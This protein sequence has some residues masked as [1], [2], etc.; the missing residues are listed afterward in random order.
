VLAVSAGDDR[1]DAARPEFA[2]VLVVV[3]A[4]VG[5]ETL[6]ALARAA[7]L[8]GDGADVVDQR[9]QLGDVVS[10]AARQADGQRDAVAVGDDVVL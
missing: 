7:G 5:D 10:V 6:S 3:V 2:A 4:A 9:Q 1:L 8:A